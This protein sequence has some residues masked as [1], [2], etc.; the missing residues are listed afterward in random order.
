M[1]DALRVWDTETA[2]EML[3]RVRQ[4]A[5]DLVEF[6]S[7]S[8]RD[9]FAAL[10]HLVEQAARLVDKHRIC[11]PQFADPRLVDH[12]EGRR[13]DKRRL[14]AAMLATHE[15]VPDWCKL[16]DWY[17]FVESEGGT[18]APVPPEPPMAPP[19]NVISFD[20]W[21][22]KRA[23]SEARPPTPPRPPTEPRPL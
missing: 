21:R 9:D 5:H 19:E 23:A 14:A 11:E 6:G 4:V 15:P 7:T 1:P 8:R 16:S 2:E 3:T 20:A 18:R 22:A 17:R 12:V 10:S 13:A